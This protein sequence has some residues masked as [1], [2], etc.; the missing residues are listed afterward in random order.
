MVIQREEIVMKTKYITVLAILVCFS[1]IS[2]AAQEN[3]IKKTDEG[4]SILEKWIAA[5]GGR[6]RLSQIRDIRYIREMKILSAGVDMTNTLY[7]KGLACV[8]MESKVMGRIFTSVLSGE[9]GWFTNLSVGSVDEMPKQLMDILKKEAEANDRLLHPE[10]YG[11]SFTYEG[12]KLIDGNGYILLNQTANDDSVVTHYLDPDTFLEYKSV[13]VAVNSET[14]TLM[15]DYREVEG[16]KVSFFSKTRK[17][18]T[19]VMTSTLK[20]IHYNT[21]LEDSLFSKPSAQNI[22][23]P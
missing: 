21:N 22:T 19:D 11:I 23:A 20:E 9:T 14:D 5:Q 1:L 3:S 10:K 17:D 8:R 13:S 6:E 18:G 15:T 12:H 7:I 4:K 2:A 16:I